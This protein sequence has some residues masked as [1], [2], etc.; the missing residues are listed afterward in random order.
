MILSAL[1]LVFRSLSDFI[2]HF[3]FPPGK[4]ARWAIQMDTLN[5]NNRRLEESKKKAV[6][7]QKK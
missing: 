1:L 3:C 7:E 2:P 5:T 6:E 4:E